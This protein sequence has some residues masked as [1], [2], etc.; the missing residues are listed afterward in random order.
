MTS[1][2]VYVILLRHL[3]TR[4]DLGMGRALLDG[5]PVR[6]QCKKEAQTM[7]FVFYSRRRNAG[8]LL[9]LLQPSDLRQGLWTNDLIRRKGHLLSNLLSTSRRKSCLASVSWS[10]CACIAPSAVP[11]ISVSR[12]GSRSLAPW[13]A[14]C[15]G[16]LG[17]PTDGTFK[18][19][20]PTYKDL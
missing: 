15:A 16:F 18:V 8:G 2:A 3:R 9:S 17:P 20:R 6:L 7:V 14:W 10:G 19:I 11:F 5:L 12:V 13:G 4:R 1:E